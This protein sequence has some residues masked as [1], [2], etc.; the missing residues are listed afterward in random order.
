MNI[1]EG[2]MRNNTDIT[3]KLASI[4]SQIHSKSHG[5]MLGAS[6]IASSQSFRVVC[7]MGVLLKL[8]SWSAQETA[9][10]LVVLTSGRKLR[11]S[12]TTGLQVSYIKS[13]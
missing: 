3:E 1:G 7:I 10:K 4:S 13:V 11:T 2:K 9:K 12:R 6:F 5:R 8:Q